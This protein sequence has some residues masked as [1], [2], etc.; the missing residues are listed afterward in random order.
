[1]NSSCRKLA[2]DLD[3]QASGDHDISRNH[4][5]VGT[6]APSSCDLMTYRRVNKTR[7]HTGYLA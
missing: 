6:K 5:S 4:E 7:Q 2:K 3:N 1:M